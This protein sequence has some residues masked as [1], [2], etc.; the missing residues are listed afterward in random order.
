MQEKYIKEMIER[1]ATI[2][3]LEEHTSSDQKSLSFT[4]KINEDIAVFTGQYIVNNLIRDVLEDEVVN[5]ESP[6]INVSVPFNYNFLFDLLHQ[7][8]LSENGKITIRNIIRLNKNL[9]AFQNS[10]YNLEML[11]YLMPF[12]F[13]AGKGY[14][15]TVNSRSK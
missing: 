13:S 4:G 15:P 12:S 11:S 2:R 7:L 1:I 6:N 9:H 5:S 8:Y 14:Q 3:P 10:N